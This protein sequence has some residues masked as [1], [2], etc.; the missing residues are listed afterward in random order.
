[1]ARTGNAVTA[2]GA[3]DPF[4]SGATFDGWVPGVSRGGDGERATDVTSAP[5][6]WLLTTGWRR[7]GLLS[8]EEIPAVR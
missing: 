1:M 6:E 2:R 4:S 7:H 5:R 8:P 3:I